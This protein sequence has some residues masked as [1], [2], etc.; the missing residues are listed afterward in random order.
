MKPLVS[1][2]IPV[3]NGSD[4]LDQAIKS[5]IEQTYGEKEIIVV[6]DGSSDDGATEKVA[7]GFGSDITYISQPNGGVSSA[8]NTGIKRSKGEF[9]SWLSH[10]DVLLPNK[11]ERQLQRFVQIG[12]TVILYGEADYINEKGHKIGELR[13]P[14]TDPSQFYGHLLMGRVFSSPWR[15]DI[16]VANGCTMLFP[17]EVFDKVGLFNERRKVTQDYE[18]WLLMN[19]H[20]DFVLMHEPLILSRRHDKAGSITMGGLMK[21]EVASLTDLAVQLYKP[22]DS[23]FDLE[24]GKTLLALRLIPAKKN[25]YHDLMRKFWAGEKGTTDILYTSLSIIAGNA[26]VR[27]LGKRMGV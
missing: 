11:I 16:F 21:E 2:I 23:K 9:I 14:K 1:I 6:N 18:M 25:G 12:R 5:A 19:Q 7:L 26:L 22:G 15:S 24:L 17:R 27:W 10:D 13:L 8:L 4:Y 20:Y 3:Y